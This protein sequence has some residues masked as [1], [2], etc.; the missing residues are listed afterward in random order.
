MRELPVIFNHSTAEDLLAY[1]KMNMHEEK[2]YLSLCHQKHANVAKNWDMGLAWMIY[3]MKNYSVMRHIGGTGCFRTFL[4]FSKE[5]KAAVVILSNY[6]L[7]GI[8][9]LGHAIFENI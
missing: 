3:R 5:K 4:G 6:F 1:A 7:F 8:E 2:P 9:K